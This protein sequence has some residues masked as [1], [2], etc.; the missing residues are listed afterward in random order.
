M[1]PSAPKSNRNFVPEQQSVQTS[2]TPQEPDKETAVGQQTQVVT[3]GQPT[4]GMITGWSVDQQSQGQQEQLIKGQGN[5]V[6][7]HKSLRWSFLEGKFM[8]FDQFPSE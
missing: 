7:R 8:R 1:T 2:F 4:Q 6:K 5:Q 3:A